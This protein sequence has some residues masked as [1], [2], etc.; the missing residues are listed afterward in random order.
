MPVISN[1]ATEESFYI[2]KGDVSKAEHIYIAAGYTDMRKAIDGLVA[3]VQ[4][5]FKLELFFIPCFIL[6]KRIFKNKSII[7]IIQER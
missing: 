1:I 5:N 4:R 2:T 6:R 3:I 7:H